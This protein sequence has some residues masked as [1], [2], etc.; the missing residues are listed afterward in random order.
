M[1]TLPIQYDIIINTTLQ[2]EKNYSKFNNSYKINHMDRLT[3]Q[4][5]Q[6]KTIIVVIMY[7][8]IV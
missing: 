5:P 8:N 6:I 4:Y 3:V 7:Y 1:V 2:H